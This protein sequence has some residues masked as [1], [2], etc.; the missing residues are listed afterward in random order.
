MCNDYMSKTVSFYNGINSTC[1]HIVGD[2]NVDISKTSVFG[3]FSQK[4]T[5]NGK[6]IF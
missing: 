3:P 1:I 5:N 4:G 6:D 2:F